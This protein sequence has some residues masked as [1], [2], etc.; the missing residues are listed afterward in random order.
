MRQRD[1]QSG[2]SIVE[3]VVVVAAIGIIGAAGWFV[4]QH[5]RVKGTGAASGT[6]QPATST[7]PT[8]T[9]SAQNI[10][11]IPELGIQITVPDS[12]KDLTYKASTVTLRNGNQATLA[13]FSTSSLTTAD[14]SCGT[15]F[16]PLGSLEKASGQY[17]SFSGSNPA[18]GSPIDYG[19][20]VKQFSTF[21][22]SSSFPNGGGCSSSKTA[23]SD[24]AATANNGTA[25]SD[26]SAF[27]SSF[28]TIQ[29][30]N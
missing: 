15:N 26:K 25:T 13:V 21:Y 18:P 10:V 4:Y 27:S 14:S 23:G 7:Q 16:G 3:A 29:M 30:A 2:F 22:I 8:Q 1:R 28:S 11:K 24:A 17:P 5:N 6:T 20:L 12:I 9:T 19:Q